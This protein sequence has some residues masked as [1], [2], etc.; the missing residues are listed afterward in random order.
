MHA[1]ALRIGH[2]PTARLGDRLIS[3]SPGDTVAKAETLLTRH[4]IRQIP[5]LSDPFT[6]VGAVTVQSILITRLSGS[7]LILETVIRP[8]ETVSVDVEVGMIV[9]VLQNQGFVIV[10]D[11]LSR[12]SGIVTHR[13]AV[14]ELELRTSP[15]RLLDEIERRLHLIVTR[16]FPTADELRQ[17]T[18]R[19]NISSAE[20]LTLGGTELALRH[21]G[22]WQNLGW[23][24]DQ[25]VFVQEVAAVRHIRNRLYHPR[26]SAVAAPAMTDVDFLS[27]FLDWLRQLQRN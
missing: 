16:M 7:P 10:R 13:D 9:P 23:S 20:D 18:G 2:L 12:V 25:S 21:V 5:V 19:R 15:H 17:A 22:C 6:S 3:L 26:G 14:Q 11:E 27:G 4:H 24:I 1:L 8:A